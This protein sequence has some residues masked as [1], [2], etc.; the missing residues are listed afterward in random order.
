MVGLLGSGRSNTSKWEVRGK[1]EDTE[2]CWRGRG[3]HIQ[4]MT[5]GSGWVEEVA[6]EDTQVQFTDS[7][8]DKHKYSIQYAQYNYYPLR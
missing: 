8:L 5:S 3:G 2:W 7:V 6:T 4:K 1:V